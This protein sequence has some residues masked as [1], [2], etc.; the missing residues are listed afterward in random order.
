M[1]VPTI[2]CITHLPID[3]DGELLARVEGVVLDVFILH[4]TF[5]VAADLLV[6]V[7]NPA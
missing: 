4:E 1:Y 5:K 2:I 3:I 6:G 7:R